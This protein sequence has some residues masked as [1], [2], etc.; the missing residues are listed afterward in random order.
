MLEQIEKYDGCIYIV[1]DGWIP[2]AKNPVTREWAEYLV[3][4]DGKY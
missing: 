3:E 2:T 4:L 1:N